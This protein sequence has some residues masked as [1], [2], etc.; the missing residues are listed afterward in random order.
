MSF[1]Q[2]LIVW[3]DVVKAHQRYCVFDHWRVGVEGYQI[4]D[5]HGMKL[6]QHTCAVEGFP[7]VAF[8]LTAAV[9]DRHDDGD[10]MS[11]S[12]C[13]LDKSLEILIVVVR[14]HVVEM[15]ADSI[16]KAVIAYI[17]HNKKICTADRFSED[18]FC[19]SGSK[20]RAAAVHQIIV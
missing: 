16:G 18:A 10:P 6:L 7:E 17:C 2:Y 19:F 8:V 9:E 15:T 13:R 12:S 5:S 11:L 4:G 1:F 3:D 20:T 14:R